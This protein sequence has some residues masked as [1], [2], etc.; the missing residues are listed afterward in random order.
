MGTFK[1]LVAPT[2]SLSSVNPTN[3]LK[4]I[5]ADYKA[6]S[7]T[8]SMGKSSAPASP[9]YKGQAIATANS[10]KYNT[11]GPTG[12]VGWTI[13]PG[14]DPNNPQPGDYIQTTTLSPDQ[15]QLY[16]L[17]SKNQLQTGL[18][19]NGMIADA[20]A[21]QT[22]VQ[23][24]L[25]RRGTKY[26]DQNFGDQEQA[27]MTRLQNSGLSE[28]SEAWNKEMRNFGQTRDAAYADAT[29]R[30]LLGADQSQN[31][32][33]DRLASIMALSRGQTPQATNNGSQG[34]D[35]SGAANSQYQALLGQTNAD[36]ANAAATTG[37]VASLAAAA[38]MYF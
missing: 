8:L 15:Q 31:S 35:F 28:G 21:P 36:N 1:K 30:A 29:D 20:T 7:E 19:A 9:D 14:A 38:A 18:A 10:S 25:Y 22:D 13:R 23:D 6:G 37:T 2:A 33:V 3:P 24:A 27:L 16:D 5:R 34:V 11:V 4:D 32:A 26:Y 17:S 12:S